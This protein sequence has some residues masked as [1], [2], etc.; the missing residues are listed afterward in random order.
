MV[1]FGSVLA[2]TGNR[3]PTY[4]L[5]I[6]NIIFFFNIWLSFCAEDSKYFTCAKPFEC[7]DM[8]NIT[9]PFWGN[10]RPEY[11]GHPD[12]QLK[13]RKDKSVE[14]EIQSQNYRVLHF[15]YLRRTLR[16]IPLSNYGG[17]CP[18][19]Y[20]ISL[21]MNIFNYSRPTTQ[22]LT[23]F[24]NCPSIPNLLTN[25][26]CSI[27]ANTNGYNYLGKLDL[28]PQLKPPIFSILIHSIVR[29]L[30]QKSGENFST[31][32]NSFLCYNFVNDYGPTSSLEEVL[33]NGFEVVYVTDVPICNECE[34]SG[35]RCGYDQ[36]SAQ[37]I[38]FCR[39]GQNPRSCDTSPAY[40]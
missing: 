29:I 20:N 32:Q 11:C 26:T 6:I 30:E 21:N 39:D 3:T 40:Q 4:F 18:R 24:Y 22:T 12:F 36:I 19:F 1:R 13:C 31:L 37:P 10:G 15:N 35:G 27:N 7:G 2:K 25:F 5:F 23:L 14:I 38:C 17:D 16:L 9:Y 28:T 8:K 34:T 33:R